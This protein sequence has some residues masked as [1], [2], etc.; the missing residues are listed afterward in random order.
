MIM[1]SNCPR[2]FSNNCR[3]PFMFVTGTG[4]FFDTTAALPNYGAGRLNSAIPMNGFADRFEC[5]IPT[6]VCSRTIN[7]PWPMCC[8]PVFPCAN[9]KYTLS[10]RTECAASRSSTSRQSRIAVETLSALSTASRTSPN[11]SRRK[12]TQN[13]LRTRLTIVRRTCWHLCRQLCVSRKLT[14]SK[15]SKRQSRDAFERSQMSI[16]CSL[17]HVGREPNCTIS[18]RKSLLPI[19]S[20]KERARIS[21]VLNSFCDLNRHRRLRWFC[22]S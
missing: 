5:T 7:A 19:T 15:S 4:W 17:K 10:G 18:S 22:T 16:R 11:V 3:L 12:S 9:R 6:A 20:R 13:Y 8:A 2:G 1:P 21:S 14:R